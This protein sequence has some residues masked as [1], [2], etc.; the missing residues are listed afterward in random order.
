MKY[1]LFLPRAVFSIY[2][3]L[4]F[5]TI[6]LLAFPFVFAAWIST[7]PLPEDFI[8]LF[9]EAN[10][11][12]IKHIDEIVAANPFDLYDLK[13][14]YNLHLS[15]TLDERKRKGMERFLSGLKMA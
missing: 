13:K 15:Y 5:I 1:L 12:G 10:G 7:R 11:L 8:Q 4:V 9:N 14:Y 3:L 2:G 6:M